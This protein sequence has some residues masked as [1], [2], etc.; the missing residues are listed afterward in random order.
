MTIRICMIN[1]EHYPFKA[2]NTINV[3]RTAAALG[4]AGA[5]IDLVVPRL[6]KGNLS[7]KA[8]GEY[9]GVQP[10]FNLIRIPSIAPLTRI[11][12]PEKISHNLLAP[13][14][15]ILRKSDVIYSRNLPPLAFAHLMGRPWV[16][17]T[18][19]RFAEESP[20]LQR[21]TRYL[22]LNEAL[23]VVAHSKRCADNLNAIGFERDAILTA[24]SGYLE[25]EVQP[26][27]DK[28]KA[29][30][31]CGLKPHG[32]VVLH[33]G[34]ID[35]YIRVDFL[36]EI[37]LMVPEVTL[38][39]VGGY[40][41]QQEFWKKKAKKMGLEH[42]IFVANQPPSKVR[43]YLYTADVLAVVPRNADIVDPG[44][45]LPLSLYRVLPGIPMKLM[46][47]AATGIPI[48]SPD[49][50]YLTEILH[51]HENAFLYPV[52]SMEKAA[53]R[54]REIIEDKKLAK[55]VAATAQAE[56]K[57]PTWTNRGKLI[58]DFIEK[59]MSRKVGDIEGDRTTIVPRRWR[60]GEKALD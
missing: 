12:R 32:P 34:N 13:W 48:F 10:S 57:F 7:R 15:S 4:E 24:Y 41:E 39:F 53:G 59:R 27:L 44:S 19:R 17:E 22:P 25:K 49:L 36:F 26:C 40:R 38:L 1:D 35:P 2:A 6:W 14:V 20:W 50:P 21:L 43:K 9:Y 45:G 42:I 33:L 3:V 16:F 52:D 11:F 29:L 51:H 5:D 60:A 37:A 54:L 58:L 30:E 47:Y 18:Y 46:I 31:L 28:A 8:L 55:R 56:G 23:A